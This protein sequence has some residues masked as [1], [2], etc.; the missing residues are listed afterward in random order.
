MPCKREGSMPSAVK[1]LPP[2]LWTRRISGDL[3]GAFGP[4]PALAN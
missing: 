1:Y 3:Y 2:E 4:K